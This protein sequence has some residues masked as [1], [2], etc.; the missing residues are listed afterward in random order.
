MHIPEWIIDN[1]ELFRGKRVIWRTI[2]QST[3]THEAKLL[4]YRN[5]GLQI[6]RYSPRETN[7]N[8]YIGQDAM[9]RFYKDP[10]EYKNWQGKTRQRKTRKGKR[11]R[12]K[13]KTHAK[14]NRQHVKLRA[15]TCKRGRAS[16]RVSKNKKEW[17]FGFLRFLFFFS[18]IGVHACF[19]KQLS[20]EKPTKEAN[21]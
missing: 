14:Q 6:V 11:Q 4:P 20:L 9:I 13:Q 10:D 19:G 15:K 18:E 21:G 7:I 17:F 8:G 16:A 12:R 1:W 3:S 2:G 5:Q